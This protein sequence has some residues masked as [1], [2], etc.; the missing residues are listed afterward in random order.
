MIEHNL[1]SFYMLNLCQRYK[2]LI[3]NNSIIS[4]CPF[5]DT[6]VFGNGQQERQKMLHVLH[7]EPYQLHLV[8]AQMLLDVVVFLCQQF[9][10]PQFHQ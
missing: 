3:M 9:E 6:R 1:L 10:L 8:A 5:L 2:L 4:N 7:G